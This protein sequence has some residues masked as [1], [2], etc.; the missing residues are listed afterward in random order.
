[1]MPTTDTSSQRCPARESA[2]TTIAEVGNDLGGGSPR[3]VGRSGELALLTEVI[4]GIQD[5]GAAVVI[6]GDPGIG[7][8]HLLRAAAA[9]AVDAGWHVLEVTGIETGPKLPF[10]GLHRLLGS[11]LPPADRLPPVQQRSMSAAFGLSGGA[12]PELF[13]VALASLTLLTES[14]ATRPVVVLLDDM[15][16][17]DAPTTEVLAFVARRISQDPI[18]IIGGVRTGYPVAFSSADTFDLELLG[19]DDDSAR[20][21]LAAGPDLDSATRDMVLSASVGN[22]L[23]LIE[24]PTAWRSVGGRTVSRSPAELPL[25][26]RLERTFGSRIVGLPAGTR[27]AILIA[28]VSSD[29]GLAEILAGTAQLSGR[30]VTAAVL[31]PAERAGILAFDE[32]HVRFR[33][34]LVRSGVLLWESA[35]RRRSANA[36]LGEV[37][38]EQPYRRS[39]HRAQAVDGQDDEVADELE[40]GHHE[41]IRRGS[42]T[43]AIVALERAAQLTRD[44]ARR[45]QRLLLAAHYA[46][47]LGRADLVDRLVNAAQ[48]NTLSELD[49]ARVQWLREIFDDGTPGDSAR[50]FTLCDVAEQAQ[51]GGDL[52]LALNLVLNAAGR[53]WWADTGP[54][55]RARV[56]EVAEQLTGAADDPRCVAAIAVAQPILRGSRTIAHLS[57]VSVD[58]VVDADHLRLLGMAGRAVGAETLAADFLDRAETTLRSQGRL[59][60]LSHVLAL[61]GAVQ[62]DLGDLHRAFESAEEARTLARDTAQPVWTTGAA[63]LEARAAALRGDVELALARAADVE[64]SALTPRVNQFLACAQLARGIA[65]IAAGRHA[66]AYAALLPVFDPADPRHHHREQLGAVMYLAEAAVQCDRRGGAL[67]V[68]A[69]M[70]TIAALSASHVLANQL[71]YARP[72]LAGD[73]DAEQLYQQALSHDLTRWPWVRARIQLA[74]GSWL[75]RQRRGPESRQPLRLALAT[76]ELIGA[77][78]WAALARSE[79]RAAGE[80]T[81]PQPAGRPV[82]LLSAQEL[83]VARLAAEGLSNKDIGQRLFL[84][85]RT[86]AS[87]LYRIFPKLGIR[88]RAQ[89]AILIRPSDVAGSGEPMAEIGGGWS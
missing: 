83:Q 29:Q 32:S 49:R 74:Y 13:L 35:A 54:R 58:S 65:W 11:L 62:V 21:L 22:P 42:V 37:L 69:R 44:P 57:S 79:L 85:P 9:V 14:A 18:V 81:D 43:A 48:E 77:A 26:T 24:L 84:S 33:H 63:V 3:L 28:A 78:P 4:T 16:W 25:T 36:A 7:K 47:G 89:L 5:Q 34:P 38:V 6:R 56:V 87:H 80:R 41:S 52:D 12:P 61:Q 45:G 1:M 72:V 39:W 55:S 68:L 23:A 17:L 10:A 8:S 86:V 66:D 53:C 73:D 50:V 64:T 75:R 60:L 19:L 40:R 15:Q 51:A 70:E 27:D 20:E 46:F 30:P 67:E 2:A 71:L 82:E 59:G 88:S 31:E 76:L